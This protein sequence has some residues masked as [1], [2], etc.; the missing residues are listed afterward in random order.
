MSR[1]DNKSF[2]KSRS[3]R[4]EQTRKLEFLEEKATRRLSIGSDFEKLE[5]ISNPFEA[6]RLEVEPEEESFAD[7]GLEEVDM[8][9]VAESPGTAHGGDRQMLRSAIADM[10]LFA[11]FP[12]PVLDLAVDAFERQR[13][14]DDGAAVLNLGSRLDRFYVVGSGCVQVYGTRETGM[15]NGDGSDIMIASLQ[16]GQSFNKLALV[17]LNDDEATHYR[18]VASGT[19][20]VYTLHRDSYFS[21]A[22]KELA[23]YDALPVKDFVYTLPFLTPLRRTGWFGADDASLEPA[24]DDLVARCTQR[25][26]QHL[27]GV[28]KVIQSASAGYA[29]IKSGVVIVTLKMRRDETDSEVLDRQM[30]YSRGD[31]IGANVLKAVTLGRAQGAMSATI[32][33]GMITVLHPTSTSALPPSSFSRA[34]D[35]HVE[36][37]YLMKLLRA[38]EAFSNLTPDEISQLLD[39]VTRASFAAQDVVLQA[40][41]GGS[42]SMFVVCQ[43][44]A[45]ASRVTSGGG[46]EVLGFFNVGEQF[47]AQ[48]LFES[49]VSKVRT[50]T[51]AAE[52][53]LQCL[54][55]DRECFGPLIERVTSSLSREVANRKWMLETWGKIGL[56][57][58]RPGRTLGEGSYGLVIRGVHRES[59]KAFAVKKVAKKKMKTSL[60]IRQV[61]NERSLMAAC[62]HPFVCKLAGSYQSSFDLYFVLELVEGGELFDT[63][64]EEGGTFDMDAAL[65]Y[66]ANVISAISHLHRLSVCHRDI[67]T[68]NLLLQA[69]GYLKL[70]DLGFAKHLTPEAR[71]I[72]FCG[73][74]HYM[75]PEIIRF[76]PHGLPV[77]M[78]SIG[79][80]MYEMLFGTVPFERQEGTPQEIFRMVASYAG[81]SSHLLAFPLPYR[82]KSLTHFHVVDLISQL[83]APDA[84]KRPTAL[85]AAEHPAM[86]EFPLLGLEQKKFKAPH[87]KSVEE[88]DDEKKGYDDREEPGGGVRQ[89]VRPSISAA[90][91]ASDAQAEDAGTFIG[92]DIDSSWPPTSSA[93]K[94]QQY[95]DE[96]EEDDEDNVVPATSSPSNVLEKKKYRSSVS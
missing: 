14:L 76:E 69:D 39:R 35:E 75:A 51:V 36:K 86:S 55:L 32:A 57:D 2:A 81:G 31:L 54:V 45:R 38:M 95:D 74:P 65:F 5:A 56:P 62:N 16:R 58:L 13:E 83:L 42:S 12:P 72:S 9:E 85:Q 19:T 68:E 80:L 41:T 82:F 66:S 18:A 91:D 30:V 28:M 33:T 84:R 87:P 63:L 53:D 29:I 44:T 50:V 89:S 11:S 47:G 24:V 78:W 90:T 20:V 10:D 46:V 37:L 92:F 25:R 48:A 1:V 3:K 73:T 8:E 21:L 15:R 49:G 70:I 17:K 59:G 77:D 27:K 71:G 94:D 64:D 60:T 7:D 4:Q 23:Y 93:P 61:I 88:E 96:E 40:G 22:S 26:F 34:L 79:C 67:K 43:G 52:T 6:L